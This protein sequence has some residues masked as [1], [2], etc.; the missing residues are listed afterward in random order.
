MDHKAY[1]AS[2]KQFISDPTLANYNLIRESG[3]KRF[4]CCFWETTVLVQFRPP[5]FCAG[6]PLA[7]LLPTKGIC[8]GY[9][10]L[11]GESFERYQGEI[12]LRM[13]HYLAHLETDKTFSED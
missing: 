6:C 10:D 7:M 3:S 8:V 1:L 11:D 2:V 4:P 5:G 12:V 9:T 13:I